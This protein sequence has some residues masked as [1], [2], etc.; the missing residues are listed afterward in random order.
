MWGKIFYFKQ[1]G[2]RVLICL[3]VLQGSGTT[4]FAAP[5]QNQSVFDTLSQPRVIEGR[6]SDYE[7]PPILKASQYLPP[8]LFK[9]KHHRVDEKVDTFGFTNRYRIHTDYFIMDI[10]GDDTLRK[11]VQEAHALAAM[12][13]LKKTKEFGK[14][15]K[16]AATAP[17]SFAK[18]LVTSPVDTVASVPRGLW[19]YIT[20]VG[21]M[22]Q[23]N[24]EEAEDN[25]GKELIGFSE[26]KRKLAYQLGVDVYSTNQ[27]LQS[28]LNSIAWAAYSG[29]L[30][31]SLAMTPVRVLSLTKS[32]SRVNQ[33]LRDNAPEDLRKINREKL[34]KMV[35][36]EGLIEKFLEHPYYSPRHESILV[37][38]L[39]TMN[40]TRDIDKFIYRAGSAESFEDA[41][42]FQ[43]I[44]ELLAEYNENI[45]P[46]KEFVIGPTRGLPM[47]V[48]Q[49]NKLVMA[50]LVDYGVWSRPAAEWIQELAEANHRV[51]PNRKIEL[52]ITGT[53]STLA[54]GEIE[55]LGIAVTENAFAQLK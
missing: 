50:L 48:T 24:R 32:S 13:E 16:N 35:S 36:R 14:A 12:E 22:V 26:S 54:K 53:L 37:D 49:D 27:A 38:A 34:Q 28:E 43:R 9:S 11:R 45:S 23:G 19:R 51:D 15:A 52:W 47:A 55:A 41:F 21:E 46:I 8:E 20:R 29:G 33:I 30:V 39:Y 5:N 6:D 1:W 10:Q 25:V 17:F 18:N 3:F 2:I 40:G 44:A 31:V 7:N 42:L 4:A